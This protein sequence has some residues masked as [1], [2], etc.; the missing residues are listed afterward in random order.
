MIR[1]VNLSNL[2]R[3][4][5]CIAAL[6]AGLAVSA[7]AQPAASRFTV[8]ITYYKLPNGLKVVLSRDTTAPLVVIGVY[9]N[10]GFRI[11]PRN[12]TGFAHLFEHLMFEGS[13]N[14][15]KGEF[16]KLIEGNGGVSNGSTRFDFTNYF[17]VVPSHVLETMLWG[18][19]DRMKNLAVTEENLKNQQGVVGNEVKVNVLNQPY[20]GFPWL[21]MP[22]Y[23]NKNWFNAHNFYGDLKDIEA[24]TLADAKSFSQTYYSPNNAALALVGDFD[25]AQAKMW[26]EKYFAS[27]PSSKLPPQPDLSEPRQEAEQRFSRVDKLAKKPALGIAYQM[28]PR[29]TPEHYAM[30]LLD[31]ML[32]QGDDSLLTQE[33]VKKRGY[34]D[35][36]DGGI[37]LLGSQFDYNGPMLWIASLIHDSSVKPD[38]ILAAADPIV[39]ALREK[40]I[41]K[42][43]LDRAL[44]KLRSQFYQSLTQFGGFGRADLMASF[45]LFDDTP[46]LINSLEDNLRKVTPELVLKTAKEYLRPT[47]RTVLVVEAG[48]AAKAPA[49]GGGK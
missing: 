19:A 22:Q 5:G 21:D 11:E 35:S 37:N 30:V 1:E 38:Q 18:E 32:I 36:V 2:T 12:R 29:L 43:L 34:T 45:A 4:L 24:A 23:A 9:Y 46:A 31:Q 48:A 14:L 27:I 17:E 10:I 8:P 44:V 13:K 3:R 16:D 41:T 20:G 47:N 7:L 26:I 33:L 40:P 15:P 39:E 49:T 42:E 6:G 28:P 25:E